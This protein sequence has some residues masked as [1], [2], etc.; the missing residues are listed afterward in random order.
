MQKYS[1]L[2]S[3]HPIINFSQKVTTVCLLGIQKIGRHR[4]DTWKVSDTIQSRNPSIFEI[5]KTHVISTIMYEMSEKLS[6]DMS[7][8]PKRK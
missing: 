3:C 5:Q 6:R 2:N 8:G 7:C 4:N 1:A